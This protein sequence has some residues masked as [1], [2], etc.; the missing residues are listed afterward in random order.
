MNEIKIFEN[1][2]FGPVRI[3]ED[4][5]GKLLFCANDVTNALGYSNGRDAVS[6]HVDEG[7][8][9]KCDMGVVTGKKSDGTDTYQVVKTTFVNES[10]LYS[11]IFGSK[12]E[13]AKKFKYWVTSEVLPSIRKTG[14]YSVNQPSYTEQVNANLAFAEWSIK[15]L[16]L[17]EA[18]KICWS[19][20][21]GERFGL[22]TEALP[23]FV[24]AGTDHPT[25]H[26]AKDLLKEYGVGISVQAFNKLL[27]VK[28]IVKTAT[29]PGRGK[30]TH[31][32]KVL[33][34]TYDKYGQNVQDPQHQKQTQI[35]WYDN[36]FGELLRATNIVRPGSLIYE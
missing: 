35:K 13:R 5:S 14:R 7:D 16:N 6:K 29:R 31:S 23:Q 36:L 28:G 21:I 3:I 26:S 15:Q 24:N 25:L 9:A 19:R 18:S 32:W 2:D 11:L 4:A 20:K 27:E 10:G 22:V 1:S 17:N 34:P 8:V 12:L 30:K 33:Q